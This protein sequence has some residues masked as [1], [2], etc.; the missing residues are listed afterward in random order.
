MMNS[1]TLIGFRRSRN[2]GLSME[3]RNSRM[4]AINQLRDVARLIAFRE[5][6]TAGDLNQIEDALSALTAVAEQLGEE[7]PIASIK[8][9]ARQGAK[10]GKERYN[11]RHPDSTVPPP[12]IEKTMPGVLRK[13]QTTW[14]RRKA[15]LALPWPSVT[16]RVGG[17]LTSGV[18]LVMG[19]T[20]AMKTQ[21]TL[22]IALEAAGR[23]HPTLFLCLDMGVEL[24]LRALIMA[25]GTPMYWPELR[26]PGEISTSAVEQG[27]KAL[28]ELPIHID[29]TNDQCWSYDRFAPLA[30]KW[31]KTI[32]RTGSVP[33]LVVDSLQLIASPRD[34]PGE[35]AELRQ[36]A[37]SSALRHIA[38][39]WGTV[40]LA[41]SSVVGQGADPPPWFQAAHSLLDTVGQDASVFG[42]D[43]VFY[44]AATPVDEQQPSTTGNTYHLAVAKNRNGL[45]G[46]HQLNENWGRFTEVEAQR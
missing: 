30:N 40:V 24:A 45:T 4:E 19:R 20:G 21:F 32:P 34:C 42:A 39:K 2:K 11:S 33:V 10:A 13:L 37:T 5:A 15:T 41:L 17:G 1:A 8:G 7:N 28:A 18:H 44:L 16:Q 23:G 3:K 12:R 36:R 26:K 6:S 22:Q 43:T 25:G 46:W 35:D 9:A 31:L 27:S 29:V 38:R 14:E